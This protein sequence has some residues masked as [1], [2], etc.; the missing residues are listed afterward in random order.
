MARPGLRPAPAEDLVPSPSEAFPGPVPTAGVRPGNQ[1]P[2]GEVASVR[3]Y[4]M[5]GGRTRPSCAELPVEALVEAIGEGRPSQDPERRRIIELVTG[6]YLSVVELS[7]HLRLPVG[8]VRVL[9]GDLRDE[10]MVRV[11]GLAVTDA[12]HPEASLR[13]LEGVLHG[14]SAL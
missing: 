5:T 7:A 13:V 10:G 9:V 3:P 4:M 6:Q 12:Y 14:I 11:H 1:A 2:D 8:V